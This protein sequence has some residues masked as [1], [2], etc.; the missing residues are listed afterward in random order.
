MWNLT[1]AEGRASEIYTLVDSG[2]GDKKRSKR[3]RNTFPRDGVASSSQQV[4]VRDFYS[5][6]VT[7]LVRKRPGMEDVNLIQDEQEAKREQKRGGA[8]PPHGGSAASSL[9]SSLSSLVG[10]G[11]SSK[12][13]EADPTGMAAQNMEVQ[14]VGAGAGA[15]DRVHVFSLATGHLYERFLKVMMLS[16]V[17]RCSVPVTFWLL[18]NFLSPSLKASAQAMAEELGFEVEFVTYKWPEWLRRQSEKQRIIWGY[19]ILFLDVLFPLHV[20]KVIYVDADQVV[21]ADLKELW[22]MDLRGRP[23][24]YT[25]FCS[26][27]EETL[28]YQF[29]RGGF[30][31]SHLRGLPYHISA[32]YVVDLSVFR[33]MAIGD[34]L[35]SVYNMLSAD[36]NS[37]SNLDQDLPNYAQ[38][39]VPIFSLPQEWLWCESWCS[40]ETKVDAKTI[41]LCNNPQVRKKGMLGDWVSLVY[42]VW[43][44]ILQPSKGYYYLEKFRLRFIFFLQ[45]QLHT[46][47]YRFVTVVL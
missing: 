46:V 1:L 11:G 12:E 40:D 26:S 44:Q 25:P 23:Y 18:E 33:R 47:V 38:F 30:W 34:I 42:V 39:Q 20:N 35:R 4:A 16:V 15:R 21:R 10:M 37:L 19:K 24:A 14:F 43:P 45:A 7:V 36:R 13:E 8:D 17:K 9:W 29:W 41:D 32:L 3:R 2:S 31:E 6:Y 28:G 5:R 22:D 27:R